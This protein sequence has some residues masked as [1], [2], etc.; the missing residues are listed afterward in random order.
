MDQKSIFSGSGDSEAATAPS[1]AGVKAKNNGRTSATNTPSP[2]S[3]AN[4]ERHIR[5]ALQG[6]SQ[7]EAS[8][9][10]ANASAVEWKAKYNAETK[11]THHLGQELHALMAESD[12]LKSKQMILC[13][14]LGASSKKGYSAQPSS[15]SSHTQ[16]QQ[17]MEDKAPSEEAVAL[18]QG[19]VSSQDRSSQDMSMSSISSITPP[20]GTEGASVTNPQQ[21]PPNIPSNN[22][23]SLSADRAA[24]QHRMNLLSAVLESEMD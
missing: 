4:L 19:D 11:H 13:E 15:S 2:P 23:E 16:T 20:E 10:Q 12:F 21:K 18:A 24:D 9:E 17:T 3:N 14:S 1:G 5:V 7:L 22:S 6:A 8:L